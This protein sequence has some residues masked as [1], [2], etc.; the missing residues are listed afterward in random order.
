MR[1]ANRQEN[2][3]GELG[4]KIN[5]NSRLSR[6]QGQERK[7]LGKTRHVWLSGVNALQQ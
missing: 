3:F 4:V 5:L 1:S 7:P 2:I 6:W